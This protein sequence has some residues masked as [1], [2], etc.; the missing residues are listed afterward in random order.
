[1]IIREY[2]IENE[3]VFKIQF[4]NDEKFY[5]ELKKV[6]R[7]EKLAEQVYRTLANYIDNCVQVG[8][9]GFCRIK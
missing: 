8:N 5:N 2:I 1:M 3:P 7:T 6:C 9:Y 4:D